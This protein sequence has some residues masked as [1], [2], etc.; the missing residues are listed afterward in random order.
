MKH[1]QWTT[2]G[3]K[4]WIDEYKFEIL[5][6]SRRVYVHRQVRDGEVPECVTPTVKREG[7]S[8]LVWDSFAGSRI[9]DLAT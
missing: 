6:S 9:A 7:E 3:W 5:G 8:V 2:E 4:L 1:W